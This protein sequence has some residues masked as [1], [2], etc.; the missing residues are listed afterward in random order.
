MGRGPRMEPMLD[1]TIRKKI[2]ALSAEATRVHLGEEIR[3]Q[4]MRNYILRTEPAQDVQA[5]PARLPRRGMAFTSD[6]G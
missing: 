3:P 5:L 1:D 2:Q 6:D 4:R